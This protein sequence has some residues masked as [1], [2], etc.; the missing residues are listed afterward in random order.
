MKTIILMRHSSPEKGLNVPN[1]E[2]PLSEDGVTLAKKIFEFPLFDSVQYLWASPYRRAYDTAK[3]LELPVRTDSRLRERQLGDSALL[4]SEFWGRQY[5]EHDFKNPGGESLNDVRLRMTNFM[6][7]L[8]QS[9]H[10]GETA[11]V[12]SHAAAIC[13]YLLNFCSITVVNEEKKFRHI[14][15]GTQTVLNGSIATPSAFAL[16]FDDGTLI[17]LSYLQN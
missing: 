2:I 6:A 13:S 10:E 9:M 5:R 16:S 17:E 1:E 14:T 12:V 11:V 4:N 3:Q 15:H 7:E 8:L